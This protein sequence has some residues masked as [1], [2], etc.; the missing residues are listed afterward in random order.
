MRLTTALANPAVIQHALN[1]RARGRLQDSPGLARLLT[2]P[3]IILIPDISGSGMLRLDVSSQIELNLSDTSFPDGELD[4]VYRFQ[5]FEQNG[6]RLYC[7][8]QLDSNF[9][10]FKFS[11]LDLKNFIKLIVRH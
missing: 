3:L 10:L 9:R 8:Y 7:S 4:V 2:W 5:K 11:Q 6:R 1:A